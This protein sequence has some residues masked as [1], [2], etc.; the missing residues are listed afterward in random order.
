MRD[1]NWIEVNTLESPS[2]IEVDANS[3][4]GEPRENYARH[5][6]PHDRSGELWLPGVPE[7]TFL[8]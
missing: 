4:K 7:G 6:P 8:D 5:T 3:I 1:R 2:R